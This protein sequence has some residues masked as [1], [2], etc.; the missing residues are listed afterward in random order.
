MSGSKRTDVPETITD[1]QMRDI[2][3]RAQWANRHESILGPKA[4]ARRINSI[5]QQQKRHLS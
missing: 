4:T 2:Q 5:E 1:K 3:L